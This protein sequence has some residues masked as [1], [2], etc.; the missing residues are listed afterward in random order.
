MPYRPRKLTLPSQYC[1]RCGEPGPFRSIKAMKCIACDGV[2]EQEREEYHRNYQKARGR[3]LKRLVEVHPDEFD[4]LLLEERAKL[5]GV[6][7]GDDVSSDHHVV[8]ISGDE[9]GVEIS[10]H[11]DEVHSARE[12]VGS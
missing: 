1:V 5:G 8:E 6:K 4:R 3:A 12:I 9:E 7:L 10:V 11:G 2:T